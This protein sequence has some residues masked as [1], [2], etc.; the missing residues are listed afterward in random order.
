MG[1][2]QSD[3]PEKLEPQ[4]SKEKQIR[5]P[6]DDNEAVVKTEDKIYN[7]DNA[8]FKNVA[9]KKELSEQPQD[10]IKG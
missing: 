4:D 9:K 7:G 3:K 1:N 5:H 10:R 8:D 6:K 2:N